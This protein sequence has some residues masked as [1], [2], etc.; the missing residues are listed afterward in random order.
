MLMMKKLNAI[1]KIAL[2]T[3][4]GGLSFS[5]FAEV[6]QL[7]ASE[8]TR[9]SAV[10]SISDDVPVTA[11]LKCTL[12]NSTSLL[13]IVDGQLTTKGASNY[14]FTNSLTGS[15]TFTLDSLHKEV[16]FNAT[17]I[18]GRPNTGTQFC[19]KFTNATLENPNNT[20][21]TCKLQNASPSL[22]A[23]SDLFLFGA[24]N[25]CAA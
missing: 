16:T 2:A 22:T 19:L 20:Y 24:S 23:I 9:A 13:P 10:I 21:I 5:S 14:T 11:F 6:I 15:S 4:L 3:V 8:T 17:H 25:P 12:G 7:S 18:T 1:K